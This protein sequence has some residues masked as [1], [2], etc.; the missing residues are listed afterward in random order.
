MKLLDW[1]QDQTSPQEITEEPEPE[2]APLLKNRLSELAKVPVTDIMIPR[3]L[4]TALDADVQLKRVRR[5]K[6]SKVS[7][8]PVY[9][10]D[11]DR[12]LGWIE[13]EKVLELLLEGREDLNLANHVQPVAT[14]DESAKVSD[15][16]D[17][18]LKRQSPFAVVQ[19]DHLQTVGLVP[20]TEFVELL[21]GVD[22][23]STASPSTD[24]A[25]SLKAYEV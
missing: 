1:L 24:T 12:I 5:L 23:Q 18:F 4:I 11:L 25:N 3:P 16:A 10:G 14:V 13:K 17:V 8:F 20:L 19:N 7:H 22:L 9:K 21:F 6:S 15:L 2:P